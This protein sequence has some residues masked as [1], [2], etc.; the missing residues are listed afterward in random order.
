MRHL[1]VIA[2]FGALGTLSRYAVYA[3]S[4]RLLGARFAWATLIVNVVG[5][6]VIGVVVQGAGG[7]PSSLRA[8][9]TMGFLGAFTTFST[10]GFDTVRYLNAGLPGL[11]ALN[12]TA[13]VVLGVGATWLGFSA[14]RWL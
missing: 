6:F 8:G 13:N 2:L 7:W 5:C 3:W 9:A 14:A 1:L 11:A 4:E 12:V 10:F